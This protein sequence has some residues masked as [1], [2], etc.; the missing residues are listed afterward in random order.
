MAIPKATGKAMI[1]LI[2]ILDKL[3]SAEDRIQEARRM[4]FEV[5]TRCLEEERAPGELERKVL[6]NFA[7]LIPEPE[8]LD[9]A[10]MWMETKRIYSLGVGLNVV[11][12]KTKKPV[13]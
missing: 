13:E 11:D 10:W 8:Q 12:P 1:E 7:T 2:K 3:N 9:E 5:L 4:V 6:L